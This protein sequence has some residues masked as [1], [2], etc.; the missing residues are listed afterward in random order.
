MVESMKQEA[1]PL[2]VDKR[3]SEMISVYRLHLLVC[4]CWV[5]LSTP[6]LVK[7]NCGEV[8]NSIQPNK[9]FYLHCNLSGLGNFTALPPSDEQLYGGLGLLSEL[10]Y[11][12]KMV[13]D[14]RLIGIRMRNNDRRDGDAL[15]MKT[16]QWKHWHEIITIQTYA[17]AQFF[18]FFLCL[19]TDT[20][21]IRF[22]WLLIFPVFDNCNRQIGCPE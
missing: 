14:Y 2:K 16:S 7:F 13:A 9:H 8:P 4:C 17:W 15:F 11:Q 6:R 19:H 20:D 10:S 12:H 18:R 1:G 5:L 22:V 3:Q 21:F